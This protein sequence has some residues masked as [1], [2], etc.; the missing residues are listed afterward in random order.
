MTPEIRRFAQQ[1]PHSNR[2][3]WRGF[4]TAKN[5]WDGKIKE[6]SC[7]NIWF[8]ESDRWSSTP[9]SGFPQAMRQL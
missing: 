1:Y 6:H 2:F 4:W 7:I 8:D 5:R 3:Y 9:L